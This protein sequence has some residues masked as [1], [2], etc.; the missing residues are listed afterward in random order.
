[1]VDQL[2]EL[3]LVLVA[4]GLVLVGALELTR[5]IGLAE[6]LDL[7]VAVPI[8]AAAQLVVTLLAAGLGVHRLDRPTVVM[9]N[10]LVTTPL[11]TLA[12]RRP[13]AGSFGREARRAFRVLRGDAVAA[14]LAGLA[15]LALAWRVVLALALPPYGYDAISYHLPTMITWIQE[16]RIVRSPFNTC[17]AYYPANGELLAAWPT[18]LTH[19][20]SF[21]DVAQCAA[22]VAGAVAVVGIARICG[23]SGAGAPIAGSLFA[24]TPVV[25]TQANTAYVDVTFT[26][27]L[28]AAYYLILRGIESRGR[29]SRAS[30]LLG[31]VAAGLS[32]GTKPTA[33]VAVAVLLVP[34]LLWAGLRCRR[35]LGNGTALACISLLLAPTLLLGAWW[36][37][38]S[39]VVTGN[40]LFPARVELLGVRVFDGIQAVNAPPL[41]L[42]SYPGLLRPLVSWS[43]DLHFWTN[44]GYSHD[45]RVGG[46]GPVWSFVE[47]I[48]IVPFGIAMWRRNRLV[49][50]GF[51]IPVLVTVAILPYRWWSRFTLL[52]VAV[53]AIAVAWAL[54][55][56]PRARPRLAL[57]LAVVCLAGA[58]AVIAS[59]WVSPGVGVQDLAAREILETAI[60]H[61][62]S[63]GAFFG[64]DYR[65]LDG[66]DGGASIA[67]DPASVHV[68]S[69]LSGAR[70]QNHVVPLPRHGDLVVFVRTHD[71]DYVFVRRGTEADRQAR[72]HPADLASIGEGLRLQAYRV[73]PG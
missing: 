29:E 8:V 61:E 39:W 6:P 43:R 7:L 34:A 10:V 21:A 52:L 32:L 12:L 3:M 33:A 38:R 72:A 15:A 50:Y 41:D 49:V 60:L 59:A 51:L 44:H 31:G 4:T 1:V 65:W 62:P 46:L 70:L 36:Y 22:V 9:L 69:P 37:A 18:L 68:T 25:L 53:G 23:L 57:A 24:L 13:R 56:V 27:T 63:A 42:R 19:N 54:G 67:T 45:Q 47:V 5:R 14:T 28:L 20:L 71:V 30:F 40:P 73:L 58:G 35:A 16:A 55:S 11:A 48:L 66:L 2:P 64:E 26:A 17:C